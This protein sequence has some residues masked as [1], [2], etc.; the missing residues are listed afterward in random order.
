[1][2]S[3]DVKLFEQEYMP[4]KLSSAT[5]SGGSLITNWTS[6]GNNTYSAIVSQPI[7]VNQLFMNNYRVMRTRIPANQSDYLRY[8]ASL[9]DS[10][11]ALYG[12]EY[13]P[14]QFDF[15]SLVDAM[16]VDY[17]SWTESHH[18][19]DH[20]NTE[21]HTIVFTNPSN[22]SIGKYVAQGQRRFHIENVYEA[23]V[24]NS[25][26]F[27]NESRT[28][29]FMTDGTYDPNKEQMIA[30]AQE[31]VLTL[32]GNDTNNPIEDVIV[33]NIVIHH[34]A[35]N[36]RRD[37]KADSGAALFIS[38]AK[39]IIISDIEISHTGSYGLTISDGTSDINFMNSFVNDTGAGGFRS[40]IE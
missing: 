13:V 1:M 33:D 28:I 39:E 29:Y 40:Y 35:W 22:E 4:K 14:E 15:K 7:Y 23:L 27:V 16:V 20:L 18:Y 34:G 6:I 2:N 24:P 8:A 21:N 32:S 12:F 9:N 11:E 36:I 25:F 3:A 31:M 37:Q 17:H 10:T 38:N 30:P 26:C 5:L 19:I